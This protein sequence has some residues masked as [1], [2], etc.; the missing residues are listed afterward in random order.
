LSEDAVRVIAPARQHT[1]D[2]R[3]KISSV[4][5]EAPGVI[6]AT[7]ESSSFYDEFLPPLKD[8]V[9]YL[10]KVVGRC[11]VRTERQVDWPD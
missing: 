1:T 8:A 6:V 7:S 2:N 5:K 11:Q 9:L 4:D 10:E 3:I